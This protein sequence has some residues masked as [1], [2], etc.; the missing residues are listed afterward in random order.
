MG[1]LI[2]YMKEYHTDLE[3]IVPEKASRDESD[4][5]DF[6]P[7][8]DESSART[9]STVYFRNWRRRCQYN[10]APGPSKL[11]RKRH[12]NNVLFMRKILMPF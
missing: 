12:R 11:N 3:N 2:N 6:G 4:S 9:D 8:L 1:K 7:E 5:S 10:D